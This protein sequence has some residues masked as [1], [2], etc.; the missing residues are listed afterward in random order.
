MP[1]PVGHTLVGLIIFKLFGK[2]KFKWQL[3]SLF[4]IILISNFPDL[5]FF[6]GLLMGEPN[7]F[8]HGI[9][10]SLGFVVILTCLTYCG[11]KIWHIN[12]PIMLSVWFFILSFTHLMMDYFAADTS[13]PYG[14]PLLWP[15]FDTYLI[16]PVY[17]F[18][19]IRRSNELL[20][21]FPSLLSWH[22]ILAVIIEICFAFL[23]WLVF[24]AIGQVSKKY[25]R[26]FSNLLQ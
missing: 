7:R 3:T 14:E 19:D 25:S 20:Q 5:D 23:I 21:F 6:P 11:A 8:H 9:S 4:L 13:L 22:N 18:L 2:Q 15:V 24:W 17:L 26:R 16:S 1:S 12:N 10:H